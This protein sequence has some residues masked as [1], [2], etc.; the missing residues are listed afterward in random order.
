MMK[1]ERKKES[2]KKRESR[3]APRTPAAPVA[4]LPAALADQTASDIPP[5]VR[6]SASLQ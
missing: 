2:N 3:S 6:L 4:L 5:S 1:G